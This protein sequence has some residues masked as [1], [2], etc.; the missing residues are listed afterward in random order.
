MPVFSEEKKNMIR[1]IL[2]VS[3]TEHEIFSFDEEYFGIILS[4]NLSHII[5]RL[6]DQ[7]V[8]KL[9]NKYRSQMMDGFSTLMRA[10]NKHQFN[11]TTR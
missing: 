5:Q 10:K 8:W 11:I 6:V 3:N 7:E 9:Q 1:G 4:Y 2:E